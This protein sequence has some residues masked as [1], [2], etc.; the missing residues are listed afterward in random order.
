LFF[1]LLLLLQ[2]FEYRSDNMSA[3]LEIHHCSCNYQQEA[4]EHH[5]RLGEDHSASNI[6]ELSNQAEFR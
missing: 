1:L 3:H 2:L 6:S 5:E 4:Q